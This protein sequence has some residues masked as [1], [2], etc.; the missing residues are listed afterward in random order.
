MTHVALWILLLTPPL[1]S[2]D[3]DPVSLREISNRYELTWK[4]DAATGREILEAEGFRL[5]VAPGLGTALWNG[6]PLDLSS[7]ALLRN[8][9]VCVPAE[10]ARRIAALVP[11]RTKKIDPLV[12][13]DPP[14]QKWFRVVIDAGHGGTHTGGQG[15]GMMEKEINLDVSLRL[16]LALEKMGGVVTQTRM[17]DRH[18]D[19][20]VHTDLQ[21]RVDV[22][23]RKKPDLF[24]SIHANYVP[25]ESAKG[26]EFWIRKGDRE[27]RRLGDS[28]RKEFVSVFSTPDRGL[29]DHKALYVLRKTNCPAVLVEL[30]FIS[31]PMEQAWLADSAY[32]Q[33]YAEAVARGVKKYLASG[34]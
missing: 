32:R 25:N 19:S 20:D 34:K 11:R 3:A 1:V 26:F 21:H 14:V 9:E 6:V 24:L 5:V 8:G 15:G 4:S 30:G 22:V 17:R 23:N 7:P 13:R 18:F 33:K 28:I 12:L 2:P 31:N 10:M 29:K 27:C 16:G